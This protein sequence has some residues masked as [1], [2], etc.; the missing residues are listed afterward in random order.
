MIEICLIEQKFLS[1]VVFSYS[2]LVA[3]AM[4]SICPEMCCCDC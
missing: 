4:P 1:G 3:A 2:F